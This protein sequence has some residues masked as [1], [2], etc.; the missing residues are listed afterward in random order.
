MP[1]AVT[2][3]KEKTMSNAFPPLKKLQCRANFHKTVP[4]LVEDSGSVE[5]EEESAA[6]QQ[7]KQ[8]G[9]ADQPGGLL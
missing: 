8:Q 1:E 6:V 7:T 4:I 9:D 2:S 3:R 5:P